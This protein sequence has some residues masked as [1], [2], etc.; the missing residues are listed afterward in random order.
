MGPR[1][2]RAQTAAEDEGSQ[3][4]C[5]VDRSCVSLTLQR[6]S[7]HPPD[8]PSAQSLKELH[9]L[10]GT[11]EQIEDALRTMPFVRISKYQS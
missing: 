8:K 1:G 3:E 11:K 10:G 7:L 6:Y 5:P 2:P 4:G 9:E